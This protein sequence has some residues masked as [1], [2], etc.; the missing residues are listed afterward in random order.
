M[1]NQGTDESSSTKKGN[2]ANLMG[3]ADHKEVRG[4]PQTGRTQKEFLV[5]SFASNFSTDWTPRSDGLDE[6][7]NKRYPHSLHDLSI[8]ETKINPLTGTENGLN[9]EQK[10]VQV[11]EPL[12][13]YSNLVPNNRDTFKDEGPMVTKSLRSIDLEGENLESF[14]DE[15]NKLYESMPQLNNPKTKAGIERRNTAASSPKFS[16]MSM[17]CDKGAYFAPN[18]YRESLGLAS[19]GNSSQSNKQNLGNNQ[20]RGSASEESENYTEEE[21]EQSSAPSRSRYVLQTKLISRNLLV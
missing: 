20:D 19:R 17:L 12:S 21:A 10:E 14:P 11:F 1:L 2:A 15:E 13:F 8:S 7:H 4:T 9:F 16:N 6:P 5:S 18:S 3:T